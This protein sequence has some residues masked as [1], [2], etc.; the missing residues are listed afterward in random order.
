MDLTL[1]SDRVI[2]TEN[3]IK[4]INEFLSYTFTSVLRLQ[5]YLMLFDP[6]GSESSYLIVPTYNRMYNK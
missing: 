4:M 6:D 2:L 5:K 1:C 3:Q